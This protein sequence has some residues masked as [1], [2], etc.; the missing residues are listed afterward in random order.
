M[1]STRGAGRSMRILRPTRGLVKALEGSIRGVGIKLGPWGYDAEA[2]RVWGLGA[3]LPLGD[4]GTRSSSFSP[5]GPG[6]ASTS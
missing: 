2:K 6:L 5:C 4:N 1:M 3:G